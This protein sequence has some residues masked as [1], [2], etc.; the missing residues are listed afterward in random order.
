MQTF[1]ESSKINE[2]RVIRE[3]ERLPDK[4]KLFTSAE[5]RMIL[6]YVPIKGA[7][8]VAKVLGKTK[9]QVSNRFYSLRS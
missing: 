6:K 3:L 8:A 1:V 2:A 5:D 7:G 9:K 4:S